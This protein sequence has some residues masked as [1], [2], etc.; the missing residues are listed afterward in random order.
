[1]HTRAHTETDMH[2]HALTAVNSATLIKAKLNP[3]PQRGE[4]HK[5]K[6]SVSILIHLSETPM[7]GK[8]A[9]SF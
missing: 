4:A 6:L 7:H 8:I 1:M 9:N 3:T 2:P 5:T